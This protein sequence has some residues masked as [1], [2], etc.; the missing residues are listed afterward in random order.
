MNFAAPPAPVNVLNVAE[1]RQ[2]LSSIDREIGVIQ[3][4]AL[5]SNVSYLR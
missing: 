4:Q 5:E 2:S 3:P 1:K